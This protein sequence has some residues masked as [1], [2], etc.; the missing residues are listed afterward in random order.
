[1]RS[2]C[3]IVIAFTAAVAVVLL[4]SA[5]AVHAIDDNCVS[6]IGLKGHCIL[7]EQ[8]PDEHTEATL[9]LTTNSRGPPAFGKESMRCM[10]HHQEMCCF[11]RDGSGDYPPNYDSDSSQTGVGVTNYKGKEKTERWR[12][13]VEKYFNAAQVPWALQIL[14]CESVGNPYAK[15]PNSSAS[16]L[17]QHIKRYWGQ[18]AAG[19]GFRGAS[20]FNPE[21]NIAASAYLYCELQR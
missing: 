7:P 4:S 14:D 1:M 8:C 18:R 20:V 3:L 21:A 11:A 9:R 17:F 16:G 10:Q 13:L 2:N 6:Q 19:A 12:T 15:N 5:T